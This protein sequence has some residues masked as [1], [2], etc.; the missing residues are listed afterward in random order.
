MANREAA[1]GPTVPPLDSKY[2]EQISH[3]LDRAF[4]HADEETAEIDE[5]RLAIFSDHHKGA[6]N[7]ADDFR[8]CEFAYAAALGYYLESGYRLCVL[9]DAEELWEESPASVIDGY[10]EILRLERKFRDAGRY[11]RFWGNHDDVW[12]RPRQLRKLNAVLSKGPMREALKIRIRR[13]GGSDCMLFLVHGHQGTTESDKWGWLSKPVVRL[14]WRQVQR[15]TG[16]SATTPATDHRLRGTHDRAMH[17]WARRRGP[18]LILIAGHTHRPVF[19]RSVPDPPAARSVEELERL[20]GSAARE[21]NG[22]VVAALRAELEYSRTLSRRPDP[23]ATAKLPCYFNTGCC[24]F[25]DGDVT[26][27]EIADGELRL[28]RWPVNFGE[29]RPKEGE[30]PL[31]TG[32]IDPQRRILAT[33]PLSEL[34]DT[35]ASPPPGA[36]ELVEHVIVPAAAQ[37][38]AA[39]EDR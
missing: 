18:G 17:E 22:A 6:Q 29:L 38:A 13:P 35:V 11:E 23:V 19:A 37:P 39:V 2:L 28:V 25:P 14:I 4:E 16:W 33:Q 3:G 8:R 34:L 21:G 32:A 9:G 5:L 7:K 31:G 24:S 30:A 10:E 20:H 12:T 15:M 26:G 36:E 27:L 1:T